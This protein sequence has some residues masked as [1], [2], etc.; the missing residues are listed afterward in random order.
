MPR[1][2]RHFRKAVFLAL[3]HDV[4]NTAKAAAYSGMLMFFPAFIVLTA[5]IAKVPEGLTVVGEIRWVSGQI[6]P[7]D[8]VH[9]MLSSMQAR[10]PHPGRLITSGLTLSIFAGLGLMLTLMEGF[11]RAYRLPQNEW[12]FWERRIRALLLVFIVLAPLALATLLLVFG[13]A[14]ELWMVLKAGHE[15]RHFVLFFWRMARWSLAFVTSLAVL[16]A[17]YHFG[18]RRR[19]HWLHVMP[20]AVAA[21]AVWFPATLAFGWYVTRIADYTIFY[22]SFGAGIATLVW[23]YITSFSALLGAE[24]NGVFFRERNLRV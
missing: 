22:G 14:I 8:T 16:G 12:G 15:L 6:L 10:N 5:L 18:T 21:S 4:L 1:Y 7:L 23:L 9:L 19:E 2:L 24:L 17:L 20:G 13:R 3:E 11:R